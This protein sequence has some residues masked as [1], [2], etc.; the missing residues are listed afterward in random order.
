MNT[1]KQVLVFMYCSYLNNEAGCS[2]YVLV[3]QHLNNEACCFYTENVFLDKI[4]TDIIR[5]LLRFLCTTLLLI[6]RNG[7]TKFKFRQ[8]AAELWPLLLVPCN[9]ITI[10]KPIF[11][12]VFQLR[13]RQSTL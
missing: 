2:I 9:F 3:L 8:F 6:A 7:H 11:F 4:Y 12:K 10:L 5:K 13:F 1:R